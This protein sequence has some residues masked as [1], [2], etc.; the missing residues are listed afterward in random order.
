M[1]NFTSFVFFWVVLLHLQSVVLGLTMLGLGAQDM[2][3]HPHPFRTQA[4]SVGQKC[5]LWVMAAEHTQGTKGP[6]GVAGESLQFVALTRAFI[7]LPGELRRLN[8]VVA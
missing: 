2:I 4:R 1:F 6:N 8:Q 7:R 3:L 5:L